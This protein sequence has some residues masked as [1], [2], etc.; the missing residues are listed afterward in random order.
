MKDFLKDNKN[1]KIRFI[2]VCLMGND[3]HDGKVTL[4]TF[5]KAYIHSKTYINFEGNNIKEILLAAYKEL[6]YG[7]SNYQRKDQVGILLV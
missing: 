2:L 5:N 3:S 4:T 1:I 6:L 7:V